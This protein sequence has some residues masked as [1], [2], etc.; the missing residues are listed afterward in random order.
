ME[1]QAHGFSYQKDVIKRFGLVAD[2][3]YIGKWDAYCD[4]IPVSIKNPSYGNDVELADF[5]RQ[6]SIEQNFYLIVGFHDK[7]NNLIE[8]HILYINKE[9]WKGMFDSSF[10]FKLK[11]L[12]EECSNEYS[13]DDIWKQKITTLKKEWI[14][15]TSN[16]IRLRFKRDHKKQKRIQ[17]AINNKD[18]YKY[19]I[20]HYA[21]EVN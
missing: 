20:P 4:G 19:F 21:I 15:A 14:A 5:F 10:E 7:A 8:E 13:Y 9:D 17:C 1:R 2:E 6:M 18:F 12:L 11:K 3:E 16:K